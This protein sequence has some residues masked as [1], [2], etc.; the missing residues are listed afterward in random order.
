[1]EGATYKSPLTFRKPFHALSCLKSTGAK[2]PRSGGVGSG[3]RKTTRDG[4]FLRRFCVAP[5]GDDGMGFGAVE[6]G[7]TFDYA[8]PD[9][10]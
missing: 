2:Q 10:D 5:R 6:V 8:P 7:L 1:M 9:A 3:E 4:D